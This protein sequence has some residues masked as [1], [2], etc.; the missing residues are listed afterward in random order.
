MPIGRKRN[1]C[2]IFC[3]RIS[4]GRFDITCGPLLERMRGRQEGSTKKDSIYESN[5]NSSN[6]RL[7]HDSNLV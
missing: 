2:H 7:S 5:M 1:S 6:L 4:V 3:H